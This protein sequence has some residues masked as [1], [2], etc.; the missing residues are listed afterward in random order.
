MHA[1][2]YYIYQLRINYSDIIVLLKTK[3]AEAVCRVSKKI[4]LIITA[5]TG[6]KLLTWQ[7]DR[8]SEFL[9]ATFEQWLLLDLGV[10]QSFSNVEHQ[11]ENGKPERSFQAIFS[12]ARS[13]LKHADLPIKM[14][15]KAV[16][17][18]AYIMNRTPAACT[19][20]IAPLQFRTKRSTRFIEHARIWKPRSDPCEGHHSNERDTLRPFSQRDL[21]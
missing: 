16:L 20:G 1:C 11:W 5:R 8:G 15:G 18:A 4:R 13:L 3:T 21:Y 10:K 9:N 6:D 2:N 7:F 12:P 14:W 19:G 17:H